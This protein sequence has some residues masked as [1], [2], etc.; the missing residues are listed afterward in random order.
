MYNHHGPFEVP[1]FWR[2][3]AY[4]HTDAVEQTLFSDTQLGTRNKKLPESTPQLTSKQN[5]L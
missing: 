5:C 3:S 1:D 4:Y 2:K